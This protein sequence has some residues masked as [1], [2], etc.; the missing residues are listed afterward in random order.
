MMIFCK[1]KDMKQNVVTLTGLSF[2]I[3][4]INHLGKY[5]SE[6]NIQV[7]EKKNVHVVIWDVMT[8]Q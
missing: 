3:L 6:A 4:I 8:F 1:L 7:Q 5:I 2:Y